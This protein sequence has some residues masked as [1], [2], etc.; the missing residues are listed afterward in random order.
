MGLS[1]FSGYVHD[2]KKLRLN[3][4]KNLMKCWT[5]CDQGVSQRYFIVLK[6]KFPIFIFNQNITLIYLR[7]LAETSITRYSS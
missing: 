3:N 6:I 5:F 1:G 4:N 2:S 7:K